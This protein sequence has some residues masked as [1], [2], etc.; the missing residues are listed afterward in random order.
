MGTT[1]F[2]PGAAKF[3]LEWATTDVNITASSGA[4]FLTRVR[5]AVEYF[6]DQV[7]LPD[8]PDRVKDQFVLQ[9]WCEIEEMLV[10]RGVHD[11][12][13]TDLD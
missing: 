12:G 4:S 2:A 10:E 8:N 5:E 13:I 7:E 3:L 9:Q 1:M 6:S 11:T